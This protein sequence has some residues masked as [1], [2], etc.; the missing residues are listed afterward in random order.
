MNLTT[1]SDDFS[2]DHQFLGAS[3]DDN[4]RRTLWV[5][6]LT[7]VMMIGEIAAGYLTGS[8]ALLADGFHMATHAGALGI[9]AAAYG[10]ARRNANNRRY[11]FG[12][13]KVGDLA[14]FASAMVLGLV[15][16]GIAGES[17][18][19]LFEPTSVAF[20]EATLI[21]VVGLGVNLLSAFLLAGHH[22]HHEHGHSHDH[23]H[24]HHHDN[25]LRSAYVHV[26]AD[27]LTSVLAIAAL[28]AGRYLGWVWMDP[29]MGI[30]GSIVIAKWAWNLMRDS[31]AVLLD[32]TDEP[33]A[34]EIRELLETSDD[35][36]ISD[37]HVWQ[38]GPQARAAIVSV[39]AT[40][41][42]TAEAIRERLA[43]VHELSHLTIE[44][45]SA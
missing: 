39:V 24:H 31:A 23:G 3:H 5:V 8:M 2:H 12:T 16:L 38:V 29:V 26:L 14:G 30:V 19:R 37:L 18:F 44:L 34:E 32:T 41:G 25:N 21:A 6:A 43:P 1:R 9:A 13:G 45:R 4:A 7:F 33:V 42:V 10:F 40:A 20:G 15:S 36:R 11:S 35:V 22:G 17:V 27:A 28:L